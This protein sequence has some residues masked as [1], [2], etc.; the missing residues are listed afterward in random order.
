MSVTGRTRESDEAGVVA[1]ADLGLRERKRIATKRAIQLAVLRLARENGLDQV[2]VD[3][4]SRDANISPRTFFNYFPSKESAVIGESPMNL[5]ESQ[6]AAF[7]TAG[8]GRDV[9][10]DLR[11]LMR[12]VAVLDGGDRELHQLRREVLRD[13]P[14]LFALKVATMRSFEETFVEVIEHRLDADAGIPVPD[15]DPVA[16]HAEGSSGIVAPSGA[17]DQASPVVHGPNHQRARMIAL[18]AISVLR[19]AW[20]CWAENPDPNSLPNSID[21]SF[22]ELR[23]LF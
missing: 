1:E 18:I 21:D 2:T 10:D 8:P 12:S 16:A 17:A 7:V 11:V 14:Q 15:A 4:I 6:T 20:S 23:S 13:Y 5:T 3:D 9:L 19:H 22:A